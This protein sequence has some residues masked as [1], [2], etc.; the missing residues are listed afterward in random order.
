MLT[1]K[2]KALLPVLVALEQWGGDFLFEPGEPRSVPVDAENGRPLKRLEVRSED[3]RPLGF[4]EVVV[5]GL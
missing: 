4:R 1:E 2:G 3:G 5:R